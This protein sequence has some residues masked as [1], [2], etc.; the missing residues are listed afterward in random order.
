VDNSTIF[1]FFIFSPV[2]NTKEYSY[3]LNY[4]IN[5]LFLV[6]FTSRKLSITPKSIIIQYYNPLILITIKN[7]YSLPVI[8]RQYL[9][10]SLDSFWYLENSLF[11]L[12]PPSFLTI[13]YLSTILYSLGP[14][15][16]VFSAKANS[17]SSP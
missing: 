3:T 6:V 7:C 17:R 13:D 12:I 16:Q 5:L 11:P 10:L 14:S 9:Y 1:F 4:Y 2:T 15:I 8:Y